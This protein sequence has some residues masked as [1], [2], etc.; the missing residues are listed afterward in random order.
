MAGYTK[1]ME[2]ML[3]S[4]P[5]MRDRIQFYINFPDYNAVELM[6][7][8]TEMCTNNGYTLTGEGAKAAKEG[9]EKLE[10]NK[11]ANFANA[12]T[13]RAIFDK[14]KIQQAY[15][16]KSMEIIESDIKSIFDK[17]LTKKKVLTKK[18]RPIGF[19]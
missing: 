7:I 8:F 14:M 17:E 19:L 1:K 16:T 6:K 3:N 12:R 10:K 9:F 4:N 18:E 15:R 13:V 11:G 5:G 2:Y